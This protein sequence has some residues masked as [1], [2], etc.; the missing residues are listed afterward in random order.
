[1]HKKINTGIFTNIAP[2]YIRP[3]WDKLVASK[4]I[5]Y[6]FI[7]SAIG[8]EGIKTILPNDFIEKNRADE[9]DWRFVKNIY[10]GPIL[11]YQLGVLKQVLRN[12]FD[13]YVFSGEMYTISTWIAAIICRIRH[14]PVFFWGH[15]YYGNEGF[16]KKYFRLL[17]YKIAGYHFLYGNR[18]RNLLIDLGFKPDRLFTVYN[19]LDYDLHSQLYY[20]R[21]SRILDELKTELLHSN[22]QYPTLVFIGRLTKKKKLSLL[23]DALYLLREKGNQINCILIGDG[24]EKASLVETVRQYGM[25]GNVYFYGSC[26]DDVQTANLIMLAD[27]CVSPGNV[28]LTAIHCMS[29]GTPIITHDQFGHQMP[30]VEA[31]VKNKTGFFFKEDNVESLSFAIDHFTSAGKK[32]KMESAC[33]EMIREHFNPQ[34]QCRIISDTVREAYSAKHPHK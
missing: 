15:G 14:K 21:N 5:R 28:G 19:S 29:L 7:S 33:I 17:F 24:E 4:D 30:E 22:N 9:P 32:Q 12:E 10:L 20:N 2:L 18:A 34:N 25:E 8:Y 3:L 13:V 6:T 31:V 1:M 11:V 27:C 16:L 23:I 26:Y